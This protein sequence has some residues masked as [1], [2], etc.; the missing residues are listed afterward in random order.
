MMREFN[1]FP[2]YP[3]A[4]RVANRTIEN[5]I[6]AS[7]RD[8]EFYD[9]DRQNGF[10]GMANDGRWG[11]VAEN[12]IKVY[13]L[14]KES[15]VLQVGC[16]KGFL[17][18]ELL[19]RGINVRGTEVSD[20]A[21]SK[22]PA[23]LMGFVRKSPFHKIPFGTREFDLVVAV[24]N[25]YCLTLADAIKCL[26][27][28]GRVSRGKSFITLMTYE[29]QD[30]YFLMKKWSILGALFLTRAEWLTV[31][32][33]CGYQSDYAFESAQHLGLTEE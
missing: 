14:T 17:L 30:E 15:M 13:G 5:R 25:V 2:E 10:G 32:N 7:Y 33:H 24:N 19:A 31:L 8:K 18:S 4:K 12:L 28:I 6:A 9:G 29:T 16:H 21:I 27:E 11:P 20:Y 26:R 1:S 22:I 23:E 3:P